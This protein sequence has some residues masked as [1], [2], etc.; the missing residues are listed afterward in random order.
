MQSSVAPY[1]ICV[2][3]WDITALHQARKNLGQWRNF[4]SLT[5]LRLERL[6]RS[7]LRCADWQAAS[8][9]WWA[10]ANRLLADYSEDLEN[11]AAVDN[12]EA[13]RKALT[14]EFASK[15]LSRGVFLHLPAF[16]AHYFGF[17]DN[18][19]G[20]ERVLYRATKLHLSHL[21]PL[22]ESGVTLSMLVELDIDGPAAEED[23]AERFFAPGDEKPQLRATA[24]SLELASI[25]R[26]TYGNRFR[27]YKER[28]D[29]GKTREK[30]IGTES[31]IYRNQAKAADHIYHQLS[32]QVSQE[33]RTV[34]GVSREH[35]PRHRPLA[36]NPQNNENLER[37][38]AAAAKTKAKKIEESKQRQQH[39][40]R[41]PYPAEAEALR[42]ASLI[43]SAGPP[44]ASDYLKKPFLQV[45]DLCTAPT[46]SPRLPQQKMDIFRPCNRSSPT[47]V[48]TALRRSDLV[49]ISSWRHLQAAPK[50]GDVPSEPQFLQ[51]LG[52]VGVCMRCMVH[53]FCHSLASSLSSSLWIVASSVL[54]AFLHPSI[55]GWCGFGQAVHSGRKLQETGACRA[56]RTDLVPEEPH[57][58]WG[59]LRA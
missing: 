20:A 27:L 54:E 58:N 11:G 33:S 48:L 14:P 6:L 55:F 21:G 13:W 37:L 38:F 50:P 17:K 39:P 3:V 46:Q 25:W 23:F 40:S 12:R 7:C 29:K 31:S 15:T 59:E 56:A 18:S 10:A 24:L 41:A 52:M 44:G 2:C 1:L 34:L 8:R 28:K 9:E 42:K 51:G 36:D 5:N 19:T 43:C 35:L 4:E 26:S 57:P 22:Q 16:V 30:R 32:K 45:I 53:E 49:V 47:D